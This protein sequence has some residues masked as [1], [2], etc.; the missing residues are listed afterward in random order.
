MVF[1]STHPKTK[2]STEKSSGKK[3]KS[4]WIF[5]AACIGTG[6]IHASR[7]VA[8][9][10]S[11]EHSFVFCHVNGRAGQHFLLRC[12]DKTICND[13]AFVETWIYLYTISASK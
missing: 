2:K 9:V 10:Q 4:L 6:V 11:A 7:T 12:E 13:L 8:T 3:M 1:A 5:N